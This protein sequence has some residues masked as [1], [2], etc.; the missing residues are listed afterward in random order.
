[1][2]GLS[3]TSENDK[4]MIVAIKNSSSHGN[5]PV[6]IAD[7]RPY[8]NAQANAIQG[9]GFENVN[10]LGGSSVATLTFFDIHNVSG[11]S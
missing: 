11:S 5:L 4:R 9:K 2:A 6:R 8:I 7:A 3:G 1:M 10:F